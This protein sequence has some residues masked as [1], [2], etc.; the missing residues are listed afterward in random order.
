[1][2][3]ATFVLSRNDTA[4][5]KVDNIPRSFHWH[6][7][8]YPEGEHIVPD[9]TLSGTKPTKIEALH[10]GLILAGKL[11]IPVVHFFIEGKNEVNIEGL[12]E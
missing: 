7:H 6:I 12:L 3:R 10:T 4:E 8:A 1:M 9:F 5:S 2:Q 11:G